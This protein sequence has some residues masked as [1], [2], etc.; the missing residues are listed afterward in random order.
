M[1]DGWP[2]TTAEIIESSLDYPFSSR[3]PGVAGLPKYL[4]TFRYQVE[5]TEYFGKYETRTPLSVGHTLTISYNPAN[6]QDNT[7]SDASEFGGP[8]R[9]LKFRVVFF[10]G[11]LLILYLW[12]RFR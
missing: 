4:N 9:T 8:R 1:A 6:P 2:E 3:E 10:I 11:F 7:G 5:G 12:S